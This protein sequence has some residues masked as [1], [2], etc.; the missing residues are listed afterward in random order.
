MCRLII[1][2]K[3]RNQE[4]LYG[5]LRSSLLIIRSKRVLRKIRTSRGMS[6][7]FV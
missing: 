6:R 5:A 1:E 4:V 2:E 3:A 7:V